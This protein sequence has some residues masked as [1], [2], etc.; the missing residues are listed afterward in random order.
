MTTYLWA[1]NSLALAGLT[2]CVASVIANVRLRR[3]RASRLYASSLPPALTIFAAIAPTHF[4]RRATRELESLAVCLLETGRDNPLVALAMVGALPDDLDDEIYAAVRHAILRDAGSPDAILVHNRATQRLRKRA[5]DLVT[6]DVICSAVENVYLGDQDTDL[7][8][9]THQP[10]DLEIPDRWVSPGAVEGTTSVFIP[11]LPG[12]PRALK[13]AGFPN[14][15]T[16]TMDVRLQQGDIDSL[17]RTAIRLKDALMTSDYQ[18]DRS[19][20]GLLRG[21]LEV[22]LAATMSRE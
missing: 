2:I 15:K 16:C 12:V 8:V 7:L 5:A 9:D 1:L 18:G 13:L 19:V 3:H 10:S 17:V 14:W 4:E 22:E 11:L 20:R 6:E 21:A